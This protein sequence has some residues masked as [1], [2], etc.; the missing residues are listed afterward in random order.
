MI[1]PIRRS[2]TEAS[3][4]GIHEYILSLLEI[5]GVAPQSMV[6]PILLPFGGDA[7]RDVPFES[8]EQ[9][10]DFHAL[11]D[12]HDG[13]EMI[14]HGHGNQRR[15][16]TLFFQAADCFSYEA[17]AACII[18]M[19]RASVFMAERDEYR[20]GFACPSGA[21]MGECLA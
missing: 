8:P 10:S 6:E 2:C 1:R 4:Y 13:M 19:V 3:P 11:S 15:P 9:V 5:F 16:A 17:P 18:K 20:V 12:A 14:R 21:M 7:E